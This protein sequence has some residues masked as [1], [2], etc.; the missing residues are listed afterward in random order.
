MSLNQLWRRLV[1]RPVVLM[2]I[3][4]LAGLAA[5]VGWTSAD[6]QAESRAAVLVVPPWSFASEDFPN[7]LVNLTD[8][9]TQLATTMLTAVQTS[10]VKLN[11][12]ETGAT[13]Y[14]VSNLAPDSLRDPTRTAVIQIVVK[15]PNR[16]A[17]HEGAVHVIDQS[18]LLLLVMQQK[19][20]VGDPNKQAQLQVIV[21]PEEKMSAGTRQIRGAAA[22]G[23]AVFIA[24]AL[25][26]WAIESMLGRRSSSRHLDSE[27]ARE[28]DFGQDERLDSTDTGP[29]APVSPAGRPT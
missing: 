21:P 12:M 13:D 5:Y 25:L 1:R 22:F 18:R 10:E 9:A 23:V 26:F 19:A 20:G 28:Q 17:A 3:L 15:G 27:L 16:R 2:I 14:Q 8:R 11:V 29:V 24:G 4:V 7:P 6:T